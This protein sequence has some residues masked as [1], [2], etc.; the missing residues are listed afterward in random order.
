MFDVVPSA[1]NAARLLLQP[2]E[3]YDA[4]TLLQGAD[5]A[6]V[7][8]E[9]GPLA[10]HIAFCDIAAGLKCLLPKP[11]KLRIETP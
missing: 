7:R 4:R 1:S 10:F 6:R 9:F 11:T 8:S 3:D 5:L 2:R